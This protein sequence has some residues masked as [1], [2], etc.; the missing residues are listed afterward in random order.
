MPVEEPLSL[1]LIQDQLR[2]AINDQI[3]LTNT[4]HQ[5]ARDAAEAEADYKVAFARERYA[6]KS[7]DG[8][9][10][11]DTVAA[12]MALHATADLYRDYLLADAERDAIK[13][14]LFSNREKQQTLRT[15]ASSYRMLELGGN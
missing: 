5:V 2:S 15:L 10:V 12:D 4:Y 14:S 7:A 11:N 6:A 1:E 3:R 13:Q 9:K 8:K